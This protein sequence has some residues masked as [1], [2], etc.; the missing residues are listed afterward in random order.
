MTDA[1]RFGRV[2]RSIYAGSLAI[3]F[4]LFLRTFYE[5]CTIVYE[6]LTLYMYV[7]YNM[8]G[9]SKDAIH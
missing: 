7:F 8:T 4:P 5:C 6:I 9:P 3:T 1:G 2:R